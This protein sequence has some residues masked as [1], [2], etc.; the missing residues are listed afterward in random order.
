MP[1]QQYTLAWSAAS[2]AE[3]NKNARYADI[4]ASVDFVPFVIETAGVWSEGGRTTDG[5]SQQEATLYF[6]LPF[7]AS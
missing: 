2:A 5:G 4:I 3:L 6:N 7:H 1:C